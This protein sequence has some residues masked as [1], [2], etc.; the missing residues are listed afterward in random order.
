[1]QAVPPTN[2]MALQPVR[3][4]LPATESYLFAVRS[5][6]LALAGN[7]PPEPNL[8]MPLWRVRDFRDNDL[9]EAISLW[10]NPA[11]GDAEPVFSLSELVAAVRG[12]GTAVVATV[13]EKVVGGAVA[14]LDK[15]RA[16]VLRIS[17]SPE[18]RQRGIGSALLSELEDRLVQQGAHR[19]S[20][21]LSSESEIGSLALEHLGYRVRP[22]V[23]L[24]EKVE[25]LV[26]ADRGLLGQLGGRMLRPDLWNALR[27]MVHEKALIEQRVVLPLAQADLAQRA[28]LHPPRAVVLFGPPGTGKTTFAK[29]VASRLGWPFVELFPSRLAG[30]SVAGLAA[31]LREAFVQI[32]E[33]ESVVVFIDEVEEIASLRRMTAAAGGHES[34]AA[35]A[36]VS[37]AGAVG[38]TNEMLK[39]IPVFR[40][41][42]GRLLICATN[43]IRD[44]DAAFL[45]HGRF[46]YVI[47]VGPPDDEARRAVWG[48][49]LGDVP[50]DDLD[51]AA[52]AARSALFTPA[53]IEY[54]ARR[55]AQKVFERS[56]AGESEATADT[57]S[58]LDAIAT[59]RPTLTDKMIAD[60]ETDIANYARL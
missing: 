39:L 3:A 33:L 36:V 12:N 48:R 20:C 23:V 37:P 32:S 11:A 14:E 55:V 60:F 4:W 54:A 42:E 58:V 2:K 44:L 17:L 50:K 53:D 10:D 22:G 30:E 59:T 38:V 46:D 49:Y 16:W 34:M 13:G 26:S 29:A 56:V 21:L 18:W 31:A 51:M 7:R 45:R 24:F 5:P 25:S 52:I 28:G 6:I 40:E 57:E 15:D 19:I 8:G 9:D 43:S 41:R 27:G 35:A 47:P 1:M